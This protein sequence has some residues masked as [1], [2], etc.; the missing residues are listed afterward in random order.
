MTSAASMKGAGAQSTWV[1]RA[2][3]LTAV[4]GLAAEGGGEAAQQIDA[5]PWNN[6]GTTGAFEAPF[7]AAVACFL[8]A[9]SKFV[10]GWQRCRS[11]PLAY[12]LLGFTGWHMSASF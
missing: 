3:L 7:V 9:T 1:C 12:A 6:D 11:L 10:N 8:W 5:D 4:P 2:A